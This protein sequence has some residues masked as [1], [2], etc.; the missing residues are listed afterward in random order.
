MGVLFLQICCQRNEKM[1]A[2]TPQ[3]WFFAVNGIHSDSFIY[4]LNTEMFISQ[5][6]WM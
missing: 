5:N 2:K 1:I 4:W 6:V 3:K